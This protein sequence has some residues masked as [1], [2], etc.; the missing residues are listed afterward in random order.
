MDKAVQSASAGRRDHY[1]RRRPEETTLYQLVQEHLEALHPRRAKQA[2]SLCLVLLAQVERETGA[3]LPDFVQDEFDPFLDCGILA[4]GFLRLRCAD[5]AHEKLVA[6][7]ASIP[8]F[9]APKAL[10]PAAPAWAG[11]VPVAPT[12]AAF[13]SMACSRPTPG[14]VPKSLRPRRA[15]QG[16]SLAWL[17]ERAGQRN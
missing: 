10:L 11:N 4:H 8:G 3:G 2:T 9:L 17:S 1:E 7:A 13:A 15:K 5:C 16:Q 12:P 14:C 6:C